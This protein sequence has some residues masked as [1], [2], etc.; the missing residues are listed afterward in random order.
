MRFDCDRPARGIGPSPTPEMYLSAAQN[1]REI[2]LAIPEQLT[3]GLIEIQS[4][5][6]H[7]LYLPA[8]WEV[9]KVQD[10]DF[11][12]RGPPRRVLC[13]PQGLVNLVSVSRAE[14][15]SAPPRDEAPGS[16]LVGTAAGPWDARMQRSDESGDSR[17]ARVATG[18]LHARAIRDKEMHRVERAQTPAREARGHRPGQNPSSSR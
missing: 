6:D 8:G 5:A 10:C 16:I 4:T 7:P 17:S 9:A 1:D 18:G 2:G 13:Q 14:E 11:V 3:T 15:F 12:P